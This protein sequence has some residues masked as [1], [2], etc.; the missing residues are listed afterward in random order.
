MENQSS[1]QQLLT[2]LKAMAYDKIAQKEQ[3]ERE[4]MQ[5]NEQIKAVSMQPEAITDQ[6]PLE[7]LALRA[8]ENAASE[9]VQTENAPDADPDA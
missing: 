9:N 2:Q 8:E 5:I 4:L 1:K 6:L 3:V 7:D